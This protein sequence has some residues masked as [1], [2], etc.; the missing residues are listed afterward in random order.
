M[1]FSPYSCSEDMSLM[2]DFFDD[3][4]GNC[5]TVVPQDDP[6]HLWD[7]TEDIYCHHLLGNQV[8]QC[9]MSLN[10]VLRIVLD[11]LTCFLVD[12]CDNM[13]DEAVDSRAV[14]KDLRSVPSLD[15]SWCVHDDDLSDE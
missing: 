4:D 13:A 15:L 14:A 2:S 11:C 5:A 12:R 7:L 9:C 6:S 1:L 3:A 8:D 10:E